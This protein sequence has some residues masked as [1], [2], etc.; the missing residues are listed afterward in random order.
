[1]SEV[2]VI[3]LGKAIERLEES[4]AACREQPE[5]L[6]YR[7]AVIKRF[8]FA[9]ELAQSVLKKFVVA[10]SVNA[11][12]REQLTFPTLIRTASQDGVLLN[13][14]DVWIKFREARSRTS[15]V[16]DDDEAVAI[17][18]IV[19]GFLDEVR[20]L[21]KRVQEELRNAPEAIPDQKT[22]HLP[23]QEFELVRAI[24]KEHIPGKAVWVFGSRATGGRMLKRFSD[25]D[26]AVEGKLTWPERAAL[27]EAFDESLLPVKV[28]VVE[29]GLVEADF[30][31]RIEKDF[32]VVQGY[33]LTQ[34]N[35][36]SILIPF[37]MRSQPEC[38]ARLTVNPFAVSHES[39]IF[40]AAAPLARDGRV[41]IQAN[42]LPVQPS[43]L[44]AYSLP[45]ASV[46]STNFAK[47][48]S[49]IAMLI[50]IR[51]L[52]CNPFRLSWGSQMPVDLP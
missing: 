49:F 50:G 26:L 34:S 29:Q 13:G 15:H 5:Q 42:G 44:A 28:D 23:E 47:S 1:M 25:L 20:F 9:F 11:K 14:Y 41:S 37:T 7:D 48:G 3:P 52:P 2:S 31:E 35:L 24:L 19:P 4:L 8:E 22:L 36:I 38:L 32:V 45:M 43:R 33:N 6:M 39:T 51:C 18:T 16:H 21:F 30:W 10:F 40:S 17:M 12:E 27:A 46:T